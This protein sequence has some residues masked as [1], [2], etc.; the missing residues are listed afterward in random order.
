[1]IDSKRFSARDR[2]G[3]GW[4]AG[5]LAA[6]IAV[7]FTTAIAEPQPPRGGP[8]RVTTTVGMVT[9]IVRQ[10]A[11]QRAEVSGIIGEGVDPHLYKPTRNDV[12]ALMSADVVFY[13]GLVLEGKMADTLV[14]VAASGR[15]VFAVTELLDEKYLLEPPSMAGHYD[16][17]VWMDVQA[18]RRAVDAV[19]AALAVFDPPH[20]EEYRSRAARYG[21]E[22]DRLDAYV[23]QVIGSIPEPQRVLITA[24]DAFNY[25]GRAYGITVKGIQGI[26]TESEAGL[27]DINRLVDFIVERQVRAIFVETSV[28]DKNVRALS[29]GARSRGH[30]VTIGGTLFSDAMGKPGTYEGTYVGMIDHNATVIARA[31]GGSAPEGGMQGKLSALPPAASGAP[32]RSAAP[33]G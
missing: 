21:E 23:R 29:E 25:F 14:K 33:G 20:A 10:V 4:T 5:R 28:A 2:R 18:W 32:E 30:E 24:H 6:A 27:Q 11:G 26:S 17:H 1:M 3:A 22:L 13:S 16:P 15:R 8:H 12:A 9:D 19:A 31:L 7:F